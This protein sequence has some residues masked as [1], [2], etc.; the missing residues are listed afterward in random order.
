ML[1]SITY[2]VF[3]SPG[4]TQA[5]SLRVTSKQVSMQI[6]KAKRYAMYTQENP[7]K[8]FHQADHTVQTV[9]PLK[10]GAC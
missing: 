2:S 3:V 6:R 7:L 5:M 10:G 4:P 8:S 1:L 9:R